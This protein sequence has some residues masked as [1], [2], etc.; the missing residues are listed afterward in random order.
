MQRNH[1]TDQPKT[2][3]APIVV[4]YPGLDGEIAGDTSAYDITQLAGGAALD[5][6]IGS[7]GGCASALRAVLSW[8]TGGADVDLHVRNDRGQHTY[9]AN[10]TGIPNSFL[11]VDD[12]DGYGPENFYLRPMEPYVA[13]EVFVH[14]YSDHGRGP[15]TAQV[16][17]FLDNRQ[18]A[19]TSFFLSDGQYET[20][21]VFGVQ[22]LGVD[23]AAP[24]SL[25]LEPAGTLDGPES[26]PC[27]LSPL[28]FDQLP[29]K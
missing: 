4:C 6:D 21:G 3:L 20:V 29:A 15:T 19:N 13:Y 1:E 18:V 7:V 17:V 5:M 12:V 27:G 25:L 22:N 9:Y 10:K 14:Y 2:A 28:F 11:D 24:F 8:D 26:H 16:Q 23:G